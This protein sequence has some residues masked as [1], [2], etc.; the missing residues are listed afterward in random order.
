MARNIR[1]QLRFA[2]ANGK[3]LGH[4]KRSAKFDHNRNNFKD[5][6]FGQKHYHDLDVLANKLGRWLITTHP[7]IRFVY[8]ITPKI[9]S[10]YIENQKEASNDQTL[11]KTKSY[12]IKLESLCAA[13]YP[14][15]RVFWNVKRITLPD[16]IKQNGYHKIHVMDRETSDR[17]ISVMRQTQKSNAWKGVDIGGRLGLRVEEASLMKIERFHFHPCPE[18][19]YGFGF[20]DLQCGDGSKGNR[21]RIVP[22]HTAEDRDRI[23]EIL[24]GLGRSSGYVVTNTRCTQPTPINPESLNRQLARGMK[25]LSLSLYD[26]YL[27]DKLHAWR[28]M[29][30]QETYDLQRRLFNVSNER[31]LEIVNIE[32]GHSGNRRELNDVYVGITDQTTLK[33][34]NDIQKQK[35]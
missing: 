7:E 3:A 34:K 12:L 23:Q 28:K 10:E 29:Y 4:S 31:A 2:V 27:G 30:A 17:I 18:N 25:A 8:K 6:I 5:H 14:Y 15:S 35:R 13:A 9:L 16:S 32:L 1:Q 11:A 19:R 24:A 22:I 26:T 33:D 21:P 20:Y